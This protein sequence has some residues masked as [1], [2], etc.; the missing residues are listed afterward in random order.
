MDKTTS[1]FQALAESRQANESKTPKARIKKANESKACKCECGHVFGDTEKFCPECGIPVN[2]VP[3]EVFEGEDPVCTCGQALVGDEKFCPNCGAPVGQANEED[4]DPE[5]EIPDGEDDIEVV[6]DDDEVVE[7]P[8]DEISDDEI[9]EDP[10]DEDDVED[11]SESKKRLVLAPYN[12]DV[13]R[14]MGKVLES[15][16]APRPVMKAFEA[17]M[18]ER[19]STW[20]KTA[21]GINIDPTEGFTAN[22]SKKIRNHLKAIKAPR[23]VCEAFDKGQY[24]IVANYLKG[25]KGSK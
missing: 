17:K 25:K 2:S 10:E 6:I 3:D 8:E 13:V 9:V 7:D 12:E 16:K 22:E 23:S 20:L 14:Y 1:I 24:S 19:C 5:D 18:Y 21:R 15:Q 11:K 4:E